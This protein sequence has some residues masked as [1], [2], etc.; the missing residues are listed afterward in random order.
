MTSQI[1]VLNRIGRLNEETK[2]FLVSWGLHSMITSLLRRK[3]RFLASRTT[4]R[5]RL[6][7]EPL[8]QRKLLTVLVEHAK[9]TAVD[10]AASDR[11]GFSVD[12]SGNAVFVAAPGDADEGV[13]TGAAYVFGGNGRSWTQQA[14]L[15][16][17]DAAAADCGG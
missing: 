15:T 8:E 12:I 17:S 4:R 3:T 10:A 14:K 7:V 5:R 1:Y 6:A 11:F 13:D 16:A 2:D 9:L